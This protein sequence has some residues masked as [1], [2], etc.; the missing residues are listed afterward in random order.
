MDNFLL[1]FVLAMAAALPVFA[2]P[3]SVAAERGVATAAQP[4]KPLAAVREPPLIILSTIPSLLVTLDGPPRFAPIKGAKPL[5]LRVVNSRV[6]L[7]KD[8]FGRY[9]LH[10]YDGFLEAG[11]LDGPWHPCEKVAPGV[12]GAVAAARASGKTDLLEGKADP[13]SR[14]K[15]SLRNSV[16]PWVYLSLVPAELVVTR[17]TPDFVSIAGTALF[18]ARNTT[19]DLFSLQGEGTMYLLASGRWY[20]APFYP[21]PWVLLPAEELPPDFQDLPSGVKGRVRDALPP[22]TRPLPVPS[23]TAWLT[24]V[25]ARDGAFPASVTPGFTVQ[26]LPGEW[27]R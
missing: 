14:K 24:G 3:L 16:I 21:G 5:L 6:L 9:F 12:R 27:C 4:L 13:K 1:P 10:L 26:A 15:P 7:L 25:V 20:R 8:A 17:G 2:A 22:R 19:G 11:S 18:F 23:A